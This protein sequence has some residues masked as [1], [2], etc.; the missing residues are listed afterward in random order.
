[1]R[2]SSMRRTWPNHLMRTSLFEEGEHG[3]DACS[4]EHCV[5][6]HLDS[7]RDAEDASQA[8]HMKAVESPLLPGAQGLGLLLQC[9]RV[10]TTQAL[11][12]CIFVC[13]V[14]LLFVQTLFVSLECG[15]CLS[16]AS[17]ELGLTRKAVRDY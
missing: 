8:A 3:R 11:Y 14:N 4:F 17:V 2:P 12:T 6:C 13:S 7:P 9:R 5:V 15:S 10:L 16:N 1:M